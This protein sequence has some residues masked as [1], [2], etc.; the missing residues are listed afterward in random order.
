MK[1]Q[2]LCVLCLLGLLSAC[3]DSV[4]HVSDPENIIVDGQK[5]TQRDFVEKY[6]AAKTDEE[7]CVLVRRAMFTSSGK[8]KTPSIRF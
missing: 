7:S 5:M 4:P 6:C 1:Y 3:G 8:G 2:L